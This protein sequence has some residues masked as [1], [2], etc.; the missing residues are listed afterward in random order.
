MIAYKRKSK[1]NWAF[2]FVILFAVASCK[3]SSRKEASSPASRSY[4]QYAQ[5][6]Q[7]NQAVGYTEI[8]VFNPWSP[9]K[10]LQ[11]Y[12]LVDKK[13]KLPENLPEGTLIR[14]PLERVAIYSSVSCSVLSELGCRTAITGVC[15]SQ[16]IGLPFI[17]EGVKNGTILDLGQASDPDV[18]KIIMAGPEAIFSSPLTDAGYG[19]VGKTGIPMIECVDYMESTPLGRA[20]WI[21]FHGLFMGEEDRADSLFRS[22]VD[23]Y[24]QLKTL[25]GS[26]QYR[27]SV[28]TEMRYGSIWYMPGGKS[29][30]A[31]LLKDA[32]ASYCW[33]SDTTT[34]S[35]SLSFETVL[36]RAEKADCWLIKYNQSNDMTY[37]EL[38][39]NYQPYTFFEAYK[40]K[41]VYTCNTG[42][43]PY[44][45]ELPIHPEY[46]LKDLVWIFHPE[47]LPEYQPRYYSKMK[48]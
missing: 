46:L 31:Y 22:T 36:E 39:A 9:G 28:F 20:E 10:I 30:M 44:Y 45:E 13:E 23:S 7:V 24:D 1:I 43:V 19:Q 33:E 34:G 29:Y 42:K 2:L 5:G 41:N 17:R 26:V 35:V 8:T 27:P 38:A 47:L 12:I 14:T 11:R 3:P 16:Y 18:E 21:R 40:K 48:E 6:F 37:S 32:G 15:E 4:I 25:A